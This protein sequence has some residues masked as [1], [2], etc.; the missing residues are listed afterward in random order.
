MKILVA[1][2]LSA[3]SDRA[4]ARGFALAKDL[5][6]ELRI[7]HVVDAALPPELRAHS[8]EWARTTLQRETDAFSE[9]TGIKAT[10]DVVTGRPKAE[11]LRYC[12]PDMTDLIILGIHDTE[13]GNRSFAETT[14]GQILKRSLPPVLLVKRDA[15]E[16]Y[17]HVVVGVDFSLFSRAAVRQAFQIAP[18]ACFHLVHAYHVPFRTLL[19]GT[20]YAQEVAYEERLQF[21]AFLNEEMKA[22][23]DRARSFGLS[24]GSIDTIL[25]EGDPF[26]VLRGETARLAADLLVIATHGRPGLSRLLW[27]SVAEDLLDDPPCD[28]LVIRPY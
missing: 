10:L 18:S 9:A 20:G 12:Q 24:P 22:L 13:G 14:A 1:S 23:S 2:D 7:L 8:L 17:R 4:I 6:G 21:D 26:S 5:K 27:G 16:T 28:V 3:R 25:K 11:L 15:R 19:S